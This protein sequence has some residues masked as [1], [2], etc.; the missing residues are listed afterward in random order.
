MIIFCLPDKY[1]MITILIYYLQNRKMFN[2]FELFIAVIYRTNTTNL[3]R[4]SCSVITS[5]SY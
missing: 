3:N 4:L 2:Y 1:Y 5:V